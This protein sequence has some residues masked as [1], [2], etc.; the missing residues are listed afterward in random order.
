MAPDKSRRFLRCYLEGLLHFNEILSSHVE[1]AY[2][3]IKRDLKT[4]TSDILS[5]I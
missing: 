1:A 4:S 5:T 2:S 3:R